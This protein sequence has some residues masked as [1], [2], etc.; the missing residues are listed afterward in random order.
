M[1]LHTGLSLWR[2][3]DRDGIDYPRAQGDFDC[4]V[5]IIGGGVTGALLGYFF[6]KSGIHALLV[7]KGQPCHGSTS[8]STGLIQY[9]VD[10]HLISL[11][12]QVGVDRAVHAY[13]RGQQAIDELQG[14]VEQL[15]CSCGFSR[16]NSLYIA[17]L[18]E[19]S[20]TLLEEFKCRQKFGL[21]VQFLS[22]TML[23]EISSI[24]APAAI[25][26]S[27]AA[28][29][30]P[31]AFTKCVLQSA[32][33]AGLQIFAHS[34]VKTIEEFP[35]RAVVQLDEAHIVARTV[36]VATGYE[37]HE[38]LPS[39]PGEL[40]STYVVT[41]ERLRSFEG[42]PDGCLIWE[43]ARPYFYARQTNDGRA[44]V[45][46][47]DTE[48]CDD[49]QRDELV[50]KQID[51]VTAR[52]TE[53]FPAIPFQP[54]FAWAGTF[55]ETKDGLA[56][57]GKPPGKARTYFALGYGGNG[58]TFGVIAA[59]LILDLYCGRENSDAAVFSFER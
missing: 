21:P 18:E 42:W 12:N 29:F 35:D 30:D 14:I 5:V 11:I 8:V 32:A 49:H 24:S 59:R 50:A 38:F 28:Q 13:R 37:S 53:L 10:T 3:Q 20:I 58:F 56:Y 54:A 33:H 55:A 36:I 17:S 40:K 41:S 57:I 16:R 31:Y 9:D 19:D 51:R 1:D 22:R 39:A 27:H 7:D 44:M 2:A 45:G 15:K 52:F 26:S 43:T 46:G 48:F 23:S 6:A 4:D 34:K 47:A 25:L